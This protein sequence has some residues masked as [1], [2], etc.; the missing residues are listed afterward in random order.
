MYKFLSLH[1]LDIGYSH[2]DPMIIAAV[3]GD[4]E[5]ITYL[6]EVEKISIHHKNPRGVTPLL[7][8]VHN[9][10]FECVQYLLEKG[11]SPDPQFTP[12][13]GTRETYDYLLIRGGLGLPKDEKK[14]YDAIKYIK[15]KR[16]AEEKKNSQMTKW[17]PLL[18]S[19]WNNNTP[20][21]NLLLDHGSRTYQKGNKGRTAAHI[22]A[23]NQCLQQ[24][25]LLYRARANFYEADEDGDVPILRCLTHRNKNISLGV[26]DAMTEHTHLGSF[27]GNFVNPKSVE[28]P[29]D[30]SLEEEVAVLLRRGTQWNTL[31][32]FLLT[33]LVKRGKAEGIVKDI[34]SRFPKHTEE[35]EVKGQMSAFITDMIQEDRADIIK[36]AYALDLCSQEDMIE[37]VRQNAKNVIGFF[38]KHKTMMAVFRNPDK[39][40]VVGIKNELTAIH[41]AAF[42]GYVKPFEQIKRHPEILSF[43]SNAELTPVHEA[44]DRGQ[45]NVVRYIFS[46][47]KPFEETLCWPKSF[48]PLRDYPNTNT[49]NAD[50]TKKIINCFKIIIDELAATIKSPE[51]AQ[52]PILAPVKPKSI[53]CLN[54]IKI[55]LIKLSLL[56]DSESLRKKMVSLHPFAI[57]DVAMELMKAQ[58][59]ASLVRL[60]EA[61]A[62]ISSGCNRL[63]DSAV[64]KLNPITI[65]TVFNRNSPLRIIGEGCRWNFRSAGKVI[66]YLAENDHTEETWA[67]LPRF[68]LSDMG[69]M[70]ALEDVAVYCNDSGIEYV[71]DLIESSEAGTEGAIKANTMT[72]LINMNQLKEIDTLFPKIENPSLLCQI[73]ARRPVE[74]VRLRNRWGNSSLLIQGQD[75]YQKLKKPAEFSH[76]NDLILIPVNENFKTF[77]KLERPDGY[78]Q[79]RR[80]PCTFVHYLSP[81]RVIV[82]GRLELEIENTRWALAQELSNVS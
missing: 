44:I 24:L 18:L 51:T 32:R 81:Y 46:V 9:N 16:K 58:N 60:I 23:N 41:M 65:S 76:D 38:E 15:D 69:L 6:H 47:A 70:W 37:A 61:G 67:S 5:T 75:C 82:E 77:K 12:D 52:F 30:N 28:F 43:R 2:S 45:E 31:T 63:L 73:I 33:W 7:V 14:E 48:S 26:L 25:I 59:Y 21:M 62:L 22:A 11:A 50:M 54:D 1:P 68:R 55:R 40:Y 39:K 57:E 10:R 3:K 13:Q 49:M 29:W 17:T 79:V 20:M 36:H 34:L 71:L 56:T 78:I 66:K 80:I 27:G 72:K 4:V 42:F 53:A 35:P 74:T 64:T 8:A 19:A